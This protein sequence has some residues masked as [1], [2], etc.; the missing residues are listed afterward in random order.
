MSAPDGKNEFLSN[1]L[2]VARRNDACPAGLPSKS[3]IYAERAEGAELW[4]VDGKRYIDFIAG[5]GVLNVGHRHPKVQE[6]IKVQLEKVVHTAFGVA[7]YESYI[8]LAERL[9][10]LMPK[11]SQ[12][13]TMFMNTGSEAT[14]QVCK[15]ARRITGR[16]G[17]IAFEGAFHGRSLLATALTGKSDPYKIGF[18]PFPP[19]IYHAPYPNEYRGLSSDEALA[20]L[21]ELCTTSIRAEDV[22]GIIIEPVQGEGGFIPAP[23]EYLRGLRE[24][25]TEHGIMLIADEVQT[26]FARTG[27]MFAIEKSGVEPDFLVCAKSIAGGLPLSAVIG[28]AD[29]FDKIG[30]GGMGSTYGGNPVSCAAALAVLDVIEEEGLIERAEHIGAKVEACWKEL[31]EGVAKGVF[32]HVRRV[33]AMAAVECVTHGDVPDGQVAAAIQARAR[34]HGLIFLTAGK[35]A[36]VIRTHVPLTASDAIVEEG[37]GLFVKATEEVLKG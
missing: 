13:K 10:G 29:L 26:G 15:F 17:L 9:N 36:H 20:R 12:W 19:G 18:G 5:I 7:Q 2:L 33:G 35:K 11:S 21:K 6:A 16:P 23:D 3:G 4:D 25:C 1:E 34:E 28:K 8:A 24:F 31:Q 27:K 37:L 32:G 30:P 22:A 14:E